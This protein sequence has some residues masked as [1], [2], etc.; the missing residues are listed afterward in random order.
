[1]YDVCDLMHDQDFASPYKVV[2]RRGEWVKGRFMLHEPEYLNFYGPVQ[3]AN[4]KELEQLPEGDRKKGV[5][6]FLCKMPQELFLTRDN[7][8]D[9]GASDEVIWRGERYK[10]IQ[11][12]PWN[13][14]G[15]MRAFGCLKGVN[16]SADQSNP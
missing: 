12:M 13:H 16:E 5:I 14:M 11:L 2:R 4:P 8:K 6:K 10:I 7:P 1:M 9:A 3:P 15:W